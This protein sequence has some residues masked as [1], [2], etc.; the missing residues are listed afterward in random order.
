MKRHFPAL[1]PLLLPTC[2]LAVLSLLLFHDLFRSLHL[3]LKFARDYSDP[4]LSFYPFYVDIDVILMNFFSLV[5]LRVTQHH[6]KACKN[7]TLTQIL[8]VYLTRSAIGCCWY[9]VPIW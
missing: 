1:L 6:P 5:F 2:D 8:Y 4:E 3:G 9:R 7:G